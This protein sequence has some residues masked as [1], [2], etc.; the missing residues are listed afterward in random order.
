MTATAAT[1]RFLTPLYSLGEAAAYLGV[2]ESTFGT[3]AKGYVRHFD[4]RPDVK[5]KPVVTLLPSPVRGAATVPFIGLAEGLVLAAIR[6]TG[7]PLQRIRPALDQLQRSLGIDHALA[8]S[9]LYS[10]GAE[11]LYD[12]ASGRDTPDARSAR[13]LVVVRNGQLVFNKIVENYLHRIEFAPDG[14]AQVIRLPRYDGAHVVVD[15]RRG[16]GQPTFQRGGARVE[17]AMSL[18]RAGESLSTV[19]AE[20][21][22]PEGELEAAIRVATLRPAA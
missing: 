10:D 15:P 2:P 19:A 6:R 16:F 3:W 22:V 4:G 21:G 17:D 18:F 9:A 7:V 1:D 8:S 12:F 14:Y 13:Q 11:V 5:G 20:F